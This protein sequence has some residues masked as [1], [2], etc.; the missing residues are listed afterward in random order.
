MNL[1]T[2]ARMVAV[3]SVAATLGGCILSGSP[4]GGAPLVS[5]MFITHEPPAARVEVVSV[6][7]YD[8]AVW[9]GGHWSARGNDYAWTKGRWERPSAGM[10]VWESGRW[11]HE[12]R[13]WHYTEGHWR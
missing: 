1:S 2:S 6:R 12:D 8:D 13:G 9:I 3:I 5:V 11:E 4:R 7:P 10:T